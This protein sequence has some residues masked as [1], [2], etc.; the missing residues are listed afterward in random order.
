MAA[1]TGHTLDN[2][3][4]GASYA[5]V[6]KTAISAGK[7]VLTSGVTGTLPVG[8]TEAD[9]TDYSAAAATAQAQADAAQAA[10]ELAAAN[11]T[12]VREQAMID[13]VIT[14]AEQSAIDAA[15]LDAT[16]KAN[17]A[18]AAALVAT[19]AWSAEGADVT[20]TDRLFTDAT[21]RA[22]IEEIGRAHV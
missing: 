14:D 20:P 21:T 13:G 22:N 7:I 2:L 11:Y 3:A 15:A 18:E 6:A 10:A 12:D 1:L 17:A 9:V 19:Q 4:D 16:T 5:R 8:N